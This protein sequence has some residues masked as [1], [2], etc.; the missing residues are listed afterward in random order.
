V[1]STEFNCQITIQALGQ[2]KDSF[3][4]KVSG[5]TD[6]LANI[7]AAW[8][9]VSGNERRVTEHGG[10]AAESREEFVINF[11]EG[12]DASMRVVFKG[13]F[14]NIKHVKP[15]GRMNREWL[16]LTCDTGVNDG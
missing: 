2:T 9:S 14:F 10:Q 1:K 8:R 13:K 7:R 4:G 12:I 15:F 3:G 5:W 6:R 11:R 16:L